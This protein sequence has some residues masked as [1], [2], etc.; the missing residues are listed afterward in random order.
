MYDVGPFSKDSEAEHIL[1]SLPNPVFLL[2]RHDRFV[3]L[4]HAAELF[5]DSSEAMLRG[6]ALFAQVPKISSLNDLLARSRQQ[7]A[8]VADQGIEIG[9]PKVGLKLLNVQ[10]APFG[11][12]RHHDGR[13]LVTL[14]ERA[15]AERLRGQ[16]IFHGAAR[17]ISA[18][19]ALLAHEV[20]NPLAGIK[21]AA[22]LL[23]SDL[24]PENQEFSQ[25]IVEEANR[26]T[27]LLDRMEGFAGGGPVV[28][29][30]VNIHE[31]LDHCLR[32]SSV[33]Y[34]SDIAVK[35][36]YDPSLPPVNGHRDLLIQTFLNIIKNAFEAI[37]KKTKMT[38]KT[39][40]S[41]GR[42]LG[43]QR[44]QMSHVPI[45]IEVIDN[46]PGITPDLRDH[47]FDPFVSGKAGGSGLGLA[48]VASVVADHGGMVEVDSV[49]GRTVFRIN[50]PALGEGMGEGMGEG[51]SA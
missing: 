46:G 33:S 31:I 25:M 18:M 41:R 14:Q 48:L 2:D 49:P 10:I 35:R 11:E 6:T 29:A 24:S 45:Q 8:S 5:F 7:M 1:A 26:I 16:S 9:G 44:V 4:N 19:A 17:S 27:A 32:I 40:Y 21:G 37:D 22:Q 43:G 20:K 42:H 34:G 12:P 47:I 3:F 23:Q 28:M 15:L 36:Q 39:S 30:P 38:V 50:L 13:M 51:K